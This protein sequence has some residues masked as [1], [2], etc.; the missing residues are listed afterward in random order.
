MTYPDGIDALVNVNAG[1]SLALGGH[2]ARHNSVNTALDEIK[3]Y[4]AGSFEAW[5]AY[6]PTL[7]GFTPGTGTPT[8][9]AFARIGKIVHFR[10]VWTYGSGSAAAS[11]RPTLTLP[12]TA[13]NA[14]GANVTAIFFD[15]SPVNHYQ[16]AAHQTS[17]TVITMGVLGT[18]GISN[19]AS[20]TSPI[21][22]A[23]DDQIILSG[24]Y[25]A[26]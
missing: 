2:A 13:A 25:E 21:T 26:A 10:A 14:S 6:T 9:G 5:T 20:T 17:T 11:A 19:T 18:N 15:A 7:G 24:S 8:A 16:A 12:V 22:W 3:V 23:T 1:D 4:L